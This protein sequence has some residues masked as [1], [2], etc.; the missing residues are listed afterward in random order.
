MP[1]HTPDPGGERP[2]GLFVSEDGLGHMTVYQN[3]KLAAAGEPLRVEVLNMGASPRLA[4]LPIPS[5]IGA[6]LTVRTTMRRR[7]ARANPDYLITNTY[8]PAL[9]SHDLVARVPTA[10]MLDATPRQLDRLHYF[11]DKTDRIPAI[12]RLKYLLARALFRRASALLPWSSWA[13]DSLLRDY[14]IPPERVVVVPPGIDTVAWSPAE[15]AARPIPEIIFVGGDFERKGG[16]AVLDWFRGHGR[17]RARLTVVTRSPLAEEAGVRVVRVDNNAAALRRLVREA[18][19]FVLPTRADCFPLAA[20]EAM[21]SGLPVVIGDV[22]G[23]ADIVEHGVTGYR[24]PPGDAAA[25]AAALEPLVASAPVRGEMGAAGRDRAVARFDSRGTI[26]RL[27]AIGTRIAAGQPPLLSGGPAEARL[28]RRDLDRGKRGPVVA[29]R[30]TPTVGRG[31]IPE[32]HPGGRPDSL[33]RGLPSSTKSGALRLSAMPIA[34]G[35]R[36]RRSAARSASTRRRLPPC[37]CPPS[38]SVSPRS[39]RIPW[40]RRSPRSAPRPGRIGN[41]WSSARG[42]RGRCGGRPWPPRR[43]IDAWATCTSPSAG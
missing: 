8:L 34:P 21:A 43:A 20:I 3:V 35:R 4:K 28:R 41:C 37:R 14:G 12:P 17:G 19:L 5:S 16:P 30:A 6:A 42:T 38:R 32:D 39:A 7:V 15:K 23:V 2:R 40:A 25:L 29:R 1:T 11:E 27:L 13:A 22:G 24:V 31:A 18:D 36:R 10:I 33:R 9:L 26:A